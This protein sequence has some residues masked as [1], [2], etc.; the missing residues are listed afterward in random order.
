[1]LEG[2]ALLDAIPEISPISIGSLFFRTVPLKYA[3]SVQ[4]VEGARLSGG[5]FNPPKAL[6]ESACAIKDGFGLLY[7]A[8]N[9]I[10]CLF[11]CGHILRGLGASDFQPVPVEPTLLVA[12]KV[13][14]ENVLDL[15]SPAT[16]RKLATSSADL[17]SLDLRAILNH[18]GSLTPLQKLGTAI[19]QTAAFSGILTPSRFNDVIPS[20]CFDFFPNKVRLDV[21]DTHRLLSQPPA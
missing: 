10:T 17:L 1:L 3:S 6:A 4:S 13:Q 18:R 11:E 7:T 14:A 2:Q 20:F 21:H 9:P 16:Q 12:F 15:R 5:R 8:S 19:H